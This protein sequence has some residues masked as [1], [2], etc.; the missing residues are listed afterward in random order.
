MVFKVYPVYTHAQTVVSE[1]Q[2]TG[3]KRSPFE[4]KQTIYLVRSSVKF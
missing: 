2:T 4:V 3:R 1:L